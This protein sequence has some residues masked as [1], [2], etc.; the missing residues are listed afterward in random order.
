MDRV[1]GEPVLGRAAGA[2]R[3]DAGRDRSEGDAPTLT[4][5]RLEGER[6]VLELLDPKRAADVVE[7]HRSNREHLAPWSPPRPEGFFEE[8]YW[9]DRLA[10][11]E[12][13][14]RSDRGL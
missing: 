3:D 1:A 6:V 12:E 7:Y 8:G 9:R 11:C 4:L 5:P 10:A 2:P 13:E 14:W